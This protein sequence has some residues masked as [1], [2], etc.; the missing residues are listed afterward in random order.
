[1]CKCL[2]KFFTNITT[3]KYY[4]FSTPIV[5]INYKNTEKDIENINKNLN[6]YKI[7]KMFCL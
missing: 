1:M 3:K 7:K 4:I 6:K 2:F 5:P